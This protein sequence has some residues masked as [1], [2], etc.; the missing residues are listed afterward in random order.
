MIGS[1]SCADISRPSSH[2]RRPDH[3]ADR[4]SPMG[5]PPTGHSTGRM[6]ATGGPLTNT[7]PNADEDGAGA[8]AKMVMARSNGTSSD[9]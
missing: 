4:S 2:P 1:A 7:S 6:I 3:D 5:G 8:L 9:F